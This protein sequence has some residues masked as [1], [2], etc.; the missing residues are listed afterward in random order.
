MMLLFPPSETSSTILIIING[1][2]EPTCVGR[3]YRLR[4]LAWGCFFL[5]SLCI[6][7]ANSS[8]YLLFS[9]FILSC[10][11]LT[12]F[13]FF[14]S[15]NIIPPLSI[16]HLFIRSRLQSFMLLWRICPHFQT[17]GVQPSALVYD[18]RRD[19]QYTFCTWG[20]CYYLLD[21]KC[22]PRL[23]AL[24]HWSLQISFHF[25]PSW[26]FNLKQFCVKR[27]YAIRNMKS[28]NLGW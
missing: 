18:C 4:C 28:R 11:P 5:Q 1:G 10:P 20:P 16:A 3:A 22:S 8:G 26:C 7:Q 21:V 13:F 6:I 14:I 19:I 15:T 23:P 24:F 25:L 27:R 12:Y 2:G 9:H 17:V